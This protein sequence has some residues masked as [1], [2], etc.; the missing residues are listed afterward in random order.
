MLINEVLHEIRFRSFFMARE[1]VCEFLAIFFK[2]STVG[3][4]SLTVSEGISKFEMLKSEPELIDLSKINDE[5][6][7]PISSLKGVDKYLGLK[8][9]AVYEYRIRDVKEGCIGVYLEFGSCGISFIEADECLTI[10][11]GLKKYSHR[12]VY[13]CMIEI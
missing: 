3:W 8:V 5:F 11:E 7:Y 13:L 2:V 1:M 9:S 10:V 12:D 4:V 6:A